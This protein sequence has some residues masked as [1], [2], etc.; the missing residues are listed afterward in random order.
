LFLI[1]TPLSQKYTEEE[2][3]QMV[4]VEGNIRM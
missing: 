2:I 4:S 1:N 3:R